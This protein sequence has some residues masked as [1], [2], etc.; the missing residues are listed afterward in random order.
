MITDD[1]VRSG[2]MRML[3]THQT[4][5]IAPEISV[6]RSAARCPVCQ[7]SSLDIVMLVRTPANPFRPSDPTAARH[8]TQATSTAAPISAIIVNT[9]APDTA[10][11]LACSNVN[12]NV[13]SGLWR[14]SLRTVDGWRTVREPRGPYA[15]ASLLEWGS[16]TK[17]LV[18]TTAMVTLEVERPVADY[19]P[20]CLM[21]R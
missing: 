1:G 10:P 15:D 21:P 14:A 11:T 9:I 3:S 7:A 17:G 13:P 6:G 8:V 4:T 5:V 18:G 12:G 2:A 19:S 20:V 16:I